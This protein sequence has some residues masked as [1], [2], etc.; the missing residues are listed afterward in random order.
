MAMPSNTPRW[1][2]AGFWPP[3][4]PKGVNMRKRGSV[5]GVLRMKPSA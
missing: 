4:G 2:G 3:W 5:A 1:R